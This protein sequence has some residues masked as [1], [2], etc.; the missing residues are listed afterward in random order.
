MKEFV[1]TIISEM[2]KGNFSFAILIAAL[3]Q[4]IIMTISLF[5]KK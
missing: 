2:V 4:L 1:N 5:K 3:L